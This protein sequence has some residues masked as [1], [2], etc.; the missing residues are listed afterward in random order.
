VDFDTLAGG[1]CGEVLSN[2]L[3][4][5]PGDLPRLRSL[6]DLEAILPAE[7]ESS[8]VMETVVAAVAVELD[9]REN[10]VRLSS[11]VVVVCV[12]TEDLLKVDLD[13]L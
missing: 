2:S 9:L 7:I 5:P 4:E 8:S 11:P 6:R 10:L 1:R 12:Y 13:R 3:P